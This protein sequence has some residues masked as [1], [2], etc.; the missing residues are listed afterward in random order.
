MFYLTESLIP[1]GLVHSDNGQIVLAG[2]PQQLGPVLQSQLACLYGLEQS[3]LERL[4]KLP[5]Y[6]QVYWILD[7]CNDDT[8]K[9]S[10]QSMF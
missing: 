7:I 4:S 2:D 5:V 10:F 3:Y 9:Y 6:L 8:D 1:L